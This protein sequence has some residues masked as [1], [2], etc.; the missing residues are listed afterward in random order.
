MNLVIEHF[1][2]FQLLKAFFIFFKIIYFLCQHYY[3]VF[4]EIEAVIP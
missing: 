1:L 2:H 3:E 4:P